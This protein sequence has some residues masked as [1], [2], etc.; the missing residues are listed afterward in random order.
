[1]ASWADAPFTMRAAARPHP[2]GGPGNR[3]EAD[4]QFWLAD[5]SICQ[6]RGGLRSVRSA[7]SLLCLDFASFAP[8]QASHPGLSFSADASAKGSS[9]H[10]NTV[11]GNLRAVFM[12]L[13]KLERCQPAA[14]GCRRGMEC[15]ED[16]APAAKCRL[17]FLM[18]KPSQFATA[19]ARQ[20]TFVTNLAQTRGCFT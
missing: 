20:K 1:M 16:K 13:D 8:S 5:R 10:S 3:P 4:R 12:F 19:R 6:R 18:Q 7:F 11:I 14:S 9:T 17:Q 2:G 15:Q